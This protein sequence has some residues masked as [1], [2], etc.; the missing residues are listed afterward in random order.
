MPQTPQQA[1]QQGSQA[2][3]PSPMPLPPPPQQAVSQHPQQAAP[4]PSGISKEED[5]LAQALVSAIVDDGDVIEKEWV[6]KA[7][8]VVLA[9]RNDPHRLSEEMMLFRA[10]YMKQRFGKDVKLSK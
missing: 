5:S 9:N 8:Q 1:A 7:K 10:N 6:N 4:A 3:P 2:P